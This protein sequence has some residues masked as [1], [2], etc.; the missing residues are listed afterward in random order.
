MLY[1]EL[2]WATIHDITIFCPPRPRLFALIIHSIALSSIVSVNV[3]AQ[4]NT[5]A[6]NIVAE[7]FMSDAY[8]GHYCD[9]IA[10]EH[11]SQMLEERISALEG[12]KP[13]KNRYTLNALCGPSVNKFGMLITINATYEP[14]T[15]TNREA[16]A[17]KI[18]D[19]AYLKIF[20][21][22]SQHFDC[23]TDQTRPQ[24]TSIYFSIICKS[25]C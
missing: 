11:N 24:T 14:V 18:F 13:L 4:T 21:A 22:R 25:C 1:I 19:M 23:Q 20:E 12:G 15:L 2:T 5:Q 7:Q 3:L 10:N 6:D 8:M 16:N 17:K 9:Q